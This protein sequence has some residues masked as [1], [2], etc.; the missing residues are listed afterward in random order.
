MPLCQECGSK[1][2]QQLVCKEC[3]EEMVT[4]L[5]KKIR[6]QQSEILK[7]RAAAKLL[8]AIAKAGTRKFRESKRPPDTGRITEVVNLL[9]GRQP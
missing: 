7:L 3:Y 8:G 2:N 9:K 6:S 4:R 1:P 5:G